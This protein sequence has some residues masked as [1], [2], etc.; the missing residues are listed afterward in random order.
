MAKKDGKLNLTNQKISS[1]KH[2]VPETIRQCK[3]HMLE[4]LT[5]KK[6]IFTKRRQLISLRIKFTKPF[7][8]LGRRSQPSTEEKLLIYK[9]QTLKNI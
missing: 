3:I 7:W 5:W 8:L 2:Q 4:W 1:D 6:Y 9:V